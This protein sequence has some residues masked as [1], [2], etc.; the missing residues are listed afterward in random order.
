MAVLSLLLFT[1]LYT[2]KEIFLYCYYPNYKIPW[3]NALSTANFVDYFSAILYAVLYSTDPQNKTQIIVL[4]ILL[5]VAEIFY[6]G[7]LWM[8]IPYYNRLVETIYFAKITSLVYIYVVAALREI[9]VSSDTVSK[10]SFNIVFVISLIIVNI[11]AYKVRSYLSI[12]RFHEGDY[13]S[14]KSLKQ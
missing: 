6:S 2:Y 1:A 7:M 5:V 3:A 14:Q 4:V 11:A 10:V 13:K 9:I 12:K 8:T